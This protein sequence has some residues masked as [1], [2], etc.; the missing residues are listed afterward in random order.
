MILS[1]NPTTG[2]MA[3]SIELFAHNQTAY[4]AAAAMLAE[5]GKAVVWLAKWLNEQKQAYHGKRSRPL[6][7]ERVRLME[8]LGMQWELGERK[9]LHRQP[10]TLQSTPAQMQAKAEITYST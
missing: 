5:T 10:G 8:E 1:Q 6:S 4:E 7:A 2:G 3:V 9:P